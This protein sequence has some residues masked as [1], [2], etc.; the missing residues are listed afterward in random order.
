MN[1]LYAH[2]IAIIENMAE[3]EELIDRYDE[4]DPDCPEQDDLKLRYLKLRE[5]LA[6]HLTFL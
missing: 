3:T 1:S 6:E 4:A 5:E 2:M